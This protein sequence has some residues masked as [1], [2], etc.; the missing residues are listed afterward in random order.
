MGSKSNGEAQLMGLRRR[1]ES[2][3]EQKVLE[4][5]EKVKVQQT[6]G[7]VEQQWTMLL[8]AAEETQRCGR[9]C[10]HR[11]MWFMIWI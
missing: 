9:T 5:D 6:V 2:L 8:Q 7:D 10:P 1:V 4:E 11:C 3:C